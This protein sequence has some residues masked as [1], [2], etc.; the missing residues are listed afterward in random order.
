MKRYIEIIIDGQRVDL[1]EDTSVTLNFNS[2]LLSDIGQLKTDGSQ[3]IKLPRTTTND[4]IFDMALMPSYESGKTHRYLSCACYVDGVTIFDNGRC[5]LLD[6]GGNGYEIAM[7]WGLMH[8]YGQWISDKRKLTELNDYSADSVVWDATWGNSVWQGGTSQLED[9]SERFSMF[10]L[11]YNCGIA[12]KK[13]ANI[14]PS[15]TLQEIWER[16]RRENGLRFNIGAAFSDM[17]NYAVVLKNNNTSLQ[18]MTK[19]IVIQEK[20]YFIENGLENDEKRILLNILDSNVFN[21]QTYS[22]VHNGYRKNIITI[23]DIY[24]SLPIASGV[25]EGGS[26]FKAAALASPYDYALVIK[27]ANQSVIVVNPSDTLYANTLVYHVNRTI[28]VEMTEEDDGK[29]IVQIYVK[30]KKWS[31]L[32]SGVIYTPN[33]M[34]NGDIIVDGEIITPEYKNWTMPLRDALKFSRGSDVQYLNSVVYSY[35]NNSHDY[36]LEDYRLAPNLP[37]IT[38]VDFVKFICQFYGLYPLRNGDA[39]DFVRMDVLGDNIDNGHFIDW[40]EKLISAYDDSPQA[41]A[42]SLSGFSQ[43]NVIRYKR[44]ENDIVDASASLDVNDATLSAERVMADFPFAA[45]RG[46]SIPQYSINEA[47]EVVKNDLQFRIMRILWN[48]RKSTLN[49]DSS[50]QPRQIINRHYQTLRNLLGKPKTIEEEM[51][52]SLLD[53]Q[54]LDYSKPI[55][56]SKYGRFYAIDT[57]Q[58][59]SDKITSKVKLIQIR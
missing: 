26:D 34:A 15:V 43:R 51:T 21:V 35:E 58:W 8:E 5:H 45:S 7:T 27:P 31:S 3:T 46:S 22:F 30:I 1:S 55:Y 54:N 17:R 4:R 47:G 2:S 52:L 44:D 16:V 56:L 20:P 59:S 32:P 48:D 19:S 57:I 10:A 37:D 12:D 41:I 18:T 36:P 33:Y 40:S 13:F 49:F 50:M 24:L 29:D 25:G 6:S 14:H 11:N 9:G 39:L 28:E 42:Y 23:D 38:Q 53:I